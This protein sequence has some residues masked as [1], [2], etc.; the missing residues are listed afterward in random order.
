MADRPPP[1]WPG[2]PLRV[3]PGY[4]PPLGVPPHL[5]PRRPIY[6]EP[7]QVRPEAVAIGAV[8]TVAWFIVFALLG[9]TLVMAAWWTLLAG[10]IA[11]AVALVLVRFGDRGV[12]AGIAVT[13]AVGW[14]IV[15]SAI[16]LQWATTG[17]WPLW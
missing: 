5:G 14:A 11:W 12:A 16:G 9:D 3:P 7:H 2:P 6:R 10:A 4:R 13:T 8:A 1:P 17:D 15:V